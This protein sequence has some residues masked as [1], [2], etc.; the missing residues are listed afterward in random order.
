MKHFTAGN[1]GNT[2]DYLYKFH[3]AQRRNLNNLLYINQKN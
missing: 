1:Q 2:K 3:T